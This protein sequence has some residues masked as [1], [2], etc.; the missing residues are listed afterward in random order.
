MRVG[1]GHDESFTL[2]DVRDA[3]SERIEDGGSADETVRG[4]DESAE[5]DVDA[6]VEGACRV[7]EVA[8]PLSPAKYAPLFTYTSAPAAAAAAACSGKFAS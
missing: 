8:S 5:D 1:V 2:L 4:A 6:V 7:M 3:L